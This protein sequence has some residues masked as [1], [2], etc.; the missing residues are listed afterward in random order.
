MHILSLTSPFPHTLSFPSKVSRPQCG[1]L[2]KGWDFSFLRLLSQHDQL[3]DSLEHCSLPTP[4]KATELRE[5]AVRPLEKSSVHLTICI[6]YHNT[7]SVKYVYMWLLTFKPMFPV[8]FSVVLFFF[9][10]FISTYVSIR[11]FPLE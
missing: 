11:L 2:Y 9:I 5:A 8:L 7:F 1:I 4:L 6:A 3:A 10:S